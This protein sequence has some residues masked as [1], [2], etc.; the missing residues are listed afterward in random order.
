MTETTTLDPEPAAGPPED[1][2]SPAEH[3]RILA[4]IGALM[5]GMFLASLD[6][7]IVATALPTIVGDLHG[8]NHLSWVVTA[9]LLTSTI[10]TPLWGKLGDQ[11]GR[12]RFYQAAIV[13]FLG[14]SALSGLAH[15]MLELIAF[16]AVQGIG[17]GGLMVGAQ[18]IVGDVISPRLRGRYMGYFGAV[19]AVTSVA[20]PLLGG[21]FTQHLSWRWIFYINVP[22]GIVAL[23]VIAAVLHVPRVRRPHRIDYLG[24]ALLSGA[25]TA[26]ILLTTWGGT[27]YAWGSPVII[28][29]GVATVA[30][31]LLF[32]AAERHAIEPVVPL[33]LFRM[34]TFTASSAVGFIVGLIMFG[35]I[36]YLPVY[37]QTVHGATPTASGL[38]LLPL[39]VGMLLTFIPTGRLVAR[40]GRYKRFPVM[41]TAV[42]SVGMVLLTQLGATTPFWLTS[43]YMFVVGVGV[44]MVMQVLVVIVQNAVPYEQ[45]GV[46]TSTATFFRSIGGCFGVALFGAVFDNRLFAALP[47]HLPSS[48]HGM[49]QGSNI[50]A[51]PAQLNRLPPAAHHVVVGAFSH[52][53]EWVFIVA[54]PF[55]VVGF[56]LTWLIKEMPLRARAFSAAGATVSA[57]PTVTVTSSASGAGDA[58]DHSGASGGEWRPSV[59]ST[60]HA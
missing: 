60:P 52:G 34:G 22:I 54:V 46:A 17:A 49:I 41:G 58:D 11:F 45:L 4:I 32:V 50:S 47:K 33:G 13:I 29:L 53:I 26:L 42:V 31:V 12:K 40:T 24:T 7:T 2:I 27:Q 6:Q 48:V 51:N 10:S 28:G 20:G 35:A 1:E 19:F 57:E 5:L 21:L 59:T 37:L 8:L 38:E 16:R 44:G 55:A 43:L 3:R 14:G 25:A 30:L 56:A 18:A 39:V 23:F 15:D 36:I 9:Y